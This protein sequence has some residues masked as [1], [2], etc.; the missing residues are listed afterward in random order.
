MIM[1]EESFVELK[2]M[3]MKKMTMT[4]VMKKATVTMI[5]KTMMMASEVQR[6]VVRLMIR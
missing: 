1:K 2:V 6:F 5:A 3:V 4:K